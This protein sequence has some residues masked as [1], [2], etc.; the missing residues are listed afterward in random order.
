MK[1][2]KSRK[3][4]NKKNKK[5]T[6]PSNQHIARTWNVLFFSLY[7]SSLNSHRSTFHPVYTFTG[8][9]NAS[10]N[11]F[12]CAD[13]VHSHFWIVL[14]WLSVLFAWLYNASFTTTAPSHYVL[15][16]LCASLPASPWH[17]HNSVAY[18]YLY[19]FRVGH[20]F[21]C[22]FWLSLSLPLL[23]CHSCRVLL[24]FLFYVS[25]ASSLRFLVSVPKNL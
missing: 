4:S 7:F 2:K 15:T 25:H 12:L 14:H 17:L 22:C 10:F 16:V 21:C 9:S 19:R 13:L 3:K 20:Y 18:M 23:F 1:E 24:A 5:N 8:V 6:E 11:K